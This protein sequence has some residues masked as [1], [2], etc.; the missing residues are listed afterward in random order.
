[1][2]KNRHA[3]YKVNINLLEKKQDYHR[4]RRINVLDHYDVKSRRHLETIK[5]IAIIS[6]FSSLC[7]GLYG[8]LLHNVMDIGQYV[9]L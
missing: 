3:F 9:W 1:M 8:I 6:H 5:Q 7:D 4:N 2:P